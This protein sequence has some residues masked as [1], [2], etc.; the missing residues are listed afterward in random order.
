[1]D[2]KE[3]NAVSRRQAGYK[4]I[5]K[6]KEGKFYFLLIMSKNAVDCCCVSL[7]FAGG[8]K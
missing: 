6:N 1:M 2:G 3:R 7:N 8:G 5:N 4:H